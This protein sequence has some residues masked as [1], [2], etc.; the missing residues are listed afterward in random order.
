MVLYR[1]I[2]RFIQREVP[3]SDPNG[4]VQLAE[5][6][7]SRYP[8]DFRSCLPIRRSLLMLRQRY[9]PS[10]LVALHVVWIHSKEEAIQTW[11]GGV[12]WYWGRHRSGRRWNIA[13]R[14]TAPQLRARFRQG[15]QSIFFRK[16]RTALYRG[17][18]DRWPEASGP[19]YFRFG[20]R[21]VFFP[22]CLELLESVL[23]LT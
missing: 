7:H 15:D 14:S 19:A 20:R 21:I 18:V 1:G 16:I 22:W 10:R 4:H 23:I 11:D 9:L 8:A 12:H 6:E 13:R 3:G 2:R 5:A 17:A